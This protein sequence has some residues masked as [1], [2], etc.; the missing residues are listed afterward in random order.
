VEWNFKL[1]R[2]REGFSSNITN[3]YGRQRVYSMDITTAKWHCDLF[4]SNFCTNSF[5]L[6]ARSRTVLPFT[7]AESQFI[8]LWIWRNFTMM[9]PQVVSLW[10]I[11]L[12]LYEFVLVRPAIRCIREC[13][14][15]IV[16]FHILRLF[17]NLRVDIFRF[18]SRIWLKES[19]EDVGTFIALTWRDGHG[20]CHRAK[21][22]LRVEYILRNAL[23]YQLFSAIR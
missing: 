1:E 8:I 2:A 18:D 6:M 3:N 10:L 9:V 7:M 17:I 20:G 14:H 22:I 13:N 11:Y 15:Y 19:H 5:S 4:D 12:I 23:C 21:L 16:Y